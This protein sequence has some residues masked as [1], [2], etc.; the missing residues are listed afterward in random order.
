MNEKDLEFDDLNLEDI[1]KEFGSGDFQLDAE[2]EAQ[3]TDLGDTKNLLETIEQLS[4]QPEAVESP[5]EPAEQEPEAPEIQ[6]EAPQEE[7]A[8]EAQE[9]LGD[10]RD[11]T[12][13]LA[14]LREAREEESPAEE[15]AAEDAEE[16]DRDA[17][18]DTVRLDNLSEIAGEAPAYGTAMAD[19]TARIGSIWDE[20][21]GEDEDSVEINISAPIIFRPKQRLRDLKRDL[22]AGP[23]KRYYER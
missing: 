6:E 5:E 19:A 4:R 14:P 9:E 15:A 23:E 8:Q 16:T 2:E 3:H 17:M 12:D 11:L 22:I 18:D 10:T 21:K 1:M 20:E 13:S 7:I